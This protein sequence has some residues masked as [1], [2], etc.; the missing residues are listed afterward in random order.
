MVADKLAVEPTHEIKKQIEKQS[1][2]K[3]KYVAAQESCE[4][5]SESIQPEQELPAK[6]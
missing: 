6:R 4:P 3:L 5:T 1:T 2:Y